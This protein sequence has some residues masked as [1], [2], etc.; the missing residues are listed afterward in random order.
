[1]LRSSNLPVGGSFGSV[2]HSPSGDDFA[3]FDSAVLRDVDGPGGLAH[4]QSGRDDDVL[5]VL[6]DARPL[7]DFLQVT[8]IVVEQ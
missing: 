8:G 1:V 2:A 4:A 5:G 3:V 7:G 6:E